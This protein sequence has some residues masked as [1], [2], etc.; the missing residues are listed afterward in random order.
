VYA[1]TKLVQGA[2]RNT[3]HIKTEVGQKLIHVRLA[4]F[5]HDAPVMNVNNNNTEE[6]K[7]LLADRHHVHVE[8]RWAHGDWANWFGHGER[9]KDWF[10]VIVGPQLHLW[11][12]WKRIREGRER[13]IDKL[14]W[15]EGSSGW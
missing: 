3:N 9:G 4:F 13:S 14:T 5:N 7:L 6:E 2:K 8:R 1:T 12:I 11:S 10:P 15:E